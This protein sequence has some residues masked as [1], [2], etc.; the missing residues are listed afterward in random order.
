MYARTAVSSRGFT[1]IELLVVIAIIAIL[2]G[3][4]VPAVQRVQDAAKIAAGFPSLEG[5]ALGTVRTFSA[6]SPLSDALNDLG[7][8]VPA[9]QDT[10][11]PPDAALVSAIVLDLRQGKAELENVLRSL[12]NPAP[13]R[14]P[15]EL[16]AY[17]E[18]KHSIQ[19]LLALLTQ[20]EAH[21]A[22]LELIATRGIVEPSP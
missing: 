4:L 18:L 6:E 14:N 15:D 11:K 1:V 19:D 13:S 12:K 17:L 20:L 22:H 10:R 21:A 3:L 16:Q 7:S 2:I 9:V 8:L 5:A